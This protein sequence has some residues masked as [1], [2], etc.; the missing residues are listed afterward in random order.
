M[1]SIV[2]PAYN[3]SVSIAKCLH[4]VFSQT[5]DEPMEVVVVCNGCTDN[6]AE[7]ARAFRPEVTVIE[8]T[9]GSKVVALNLGDEAVT[10]FPRIYL[11]GDM[12]HIN[13]HRRL[14]KIWLPLKNPCKNA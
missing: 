6:T 3:E 1:I 14:G 10:S 12:V 13:A 5:L 7:I 9:V 4:S 8:T 11:D 2:I